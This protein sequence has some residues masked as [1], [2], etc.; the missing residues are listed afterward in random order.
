M[1]SGGRGQTA[2]I[3]ETIVGTASLSSGSVY[4]QIFNLGLFPR[5]KSLA[6]QF[7]FYKAARVTF[8]YEPLYNTFQ[9]GVATPSKPY[10]YLQMNRTQLLY[11]GAN[12]QE[13]QAS[14]ARP[15][16]FTS[17]KNISY[18]PNWCSSGVIVTN[19]SNPVLAVA[20]S[21]LKKEYTWL[22]CPTIDTGSANTSTAVI[23]NAINQTGT[24]SGSSFV[25][26]NQPVYNGH[27][28]AFDQSSGASDIARVT[29]TVHWLFKGA[30]FS[31]QKGTVDPTST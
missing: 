17:L 11:T 22:T 6:P 23:D 8:S 27:I 5:A 14:G 2:S 18:T 20:Q 3:V 29:V 28:I 19:Q 25:V 16:S 31:P 4:A 10:M 21:G 1:S 26:A 12:L 30:H 15:Q 13:L 9:E 7:Q 24:F